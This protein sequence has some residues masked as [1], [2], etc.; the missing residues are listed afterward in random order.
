MRKFLTI[1]FLLCIATV[2]FAG[3]PGQAAGIFD[4]KFLAFIGVGGAAAGCGTAQGRALAA[5][6]EG[7]ARNPQAADKIS[8]SLVLGLAFIE[9]LVLFTFALVFLLK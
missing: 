7:I 8:G 4:T 6:F 5:A 3:E 1:A 2:A 9:A